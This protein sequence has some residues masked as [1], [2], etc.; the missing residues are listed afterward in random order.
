MQKSIYK[1]YARL[2][3]INKT[4]AILILQEKCFMKNILFKQFCKKNLLPR[5]KYSFYNPKQN[6]MTFINNT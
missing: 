6:N 4:I 5:Y 3:K 2:I 1:K